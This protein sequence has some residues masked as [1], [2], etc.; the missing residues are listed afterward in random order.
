[1]PTTISLTV[2]DSLATEAVNALCSRGGYQATITNAD[3][4]TS[5][6]PVTK[7]QFAKSVIKDFIRNAITEERNK[8]ALV[9]SN[10]PVDATLIS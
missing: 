7:P 9:A 5:P 4:T 10:T 2:A 6:N 8:A 3:G 1:M